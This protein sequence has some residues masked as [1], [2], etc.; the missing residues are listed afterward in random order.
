MEYSLAQLR[1]FVAVA[2]ELHFGRAAGR[3]QM[4]QPPLTR[5]IQALERSIGVRLLDRDREVR[6]T[7]AGAAFLVD[8]RRLLAL[9]E[10]A[11]ESARR[12]AA[13]EVGTLRLGFTAI[14]A[15]AVLGPMLS[16]IHDQLPGVEVDLQ[17]LVSEEQFNAL[18][19]G[20]LDLCLVRPPVPDGLSALPVHA[21]EL[22]LAAPVA[23]ELAAG[24]EP[25]RLVDVSADYIGYSP[26]GSRYLYDV[27]AALIAVQ[28]FLG[29]EIASQFPTMLAL[30]RAGRGV[31]LI[32]R[33]CTAMRIDGV[34][35]R[36]LDAADTRTVRLEACWNPQSQ[37]P[38]LA[39][40]LPLLSEDCFSAGV[41]S[42]RRR[43]GPR[44][45][46]GRRSAAP[47]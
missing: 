46:R 26:E 9:A 47:R 42:A 22:V 15:Y 30:V 37:D 10:A 11:P 20:R 17:E 18:G 23:H 4:T 7:P 32:P 39:R 35:Y 36:E 2:D 29:A 38:V 33:S 24:D 41:L 13:G 40:V 45:R 34:V 21:E 3:L 5:Q 28:D 31:A 27:C 19:S 8:A 12:A 44:S 25:V 1:G 6:L 16:L 43:P 14:G